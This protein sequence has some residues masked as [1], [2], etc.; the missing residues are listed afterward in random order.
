MLGSGT[1]AKWGTLTG[2]KDSR[3]RFL[4]SAGTDYR[5]QISPNTLTIAEWIVG[6]SWASKIDVAKAYIVSVRWPLYS[7]TAAEI[8]IVSPIFSVATPATPAEVIRWELYLAN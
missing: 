8:W 2:F 4:A 6:Q 1:Q 5:A 7:S 3:T